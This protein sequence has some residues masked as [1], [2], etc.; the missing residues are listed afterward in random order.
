M[1]AG[2]NTSTV[3]LR[4]EGGDEKGSVKSVFAGTC[5]PSRFL[6]LGVH[7]LELHIINLQRHFLSKIR[8]SDKGSLD[9]SDICTVI[10]EC[11]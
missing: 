7:E 4:V 8:V 5:L 3:T 11:Y 1:E 10:K 6:A 9:S 2:L